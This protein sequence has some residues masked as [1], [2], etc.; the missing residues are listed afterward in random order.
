[1]DLFNSYSLLIIRAYPRQIISFTVF[2]AAD[3]C[4]YSRICLILFLFFYPRL[5]VPIRGK[6][7]FLF[8]PAIIYFIPAPRRFSSRPSHRLFLIRFP[9]PRSRKQAQSP[10]HPSRLR[11]LL[12]PYAVIPSCLYFPSACN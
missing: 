9:K 10:S 3:L 2:P 11:A 4:G 6:I 12:L 7:F 1:M 5:S 8:L